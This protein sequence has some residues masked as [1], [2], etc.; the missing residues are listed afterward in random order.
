MKKLLVSL[1]LGAAAG[2]ALAA[3]ANIHMDKFPA[4]RLRELSAVQNGAKLFS[5][6]CL[7]CHSASLMRWNRL[8]D[9]GLTEEQIKEFL[10]PGDQKVGDMMTSAMS[11]RDGRAWFGKAPPDLSV[12]VRARTSFDYKGTDYLYTLLRGYYRDSSTPTGWNNVALANIAM[13]HI[14]WELQGPREATITQV[15]HEV[16]PKTGAEEAFKQVAVYDTRG[17]VAIEKTAAAGHGAAAMEF[18]FKPADAAQARQFDSDVADL[19]A[20]LAFMTDPSASKRI[21]YGP[22][23]MLFLLLLAVVLWRLNKAYWRNIR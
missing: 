10:I 2:S 21:A 23:V 9:I 8:R 3:G 12:I 6:Y 7:G 18:A 1:L 19:V 16:N 13:P 17:N 22:W 15:V 14:L 5:N 20:F 4:E 11:A